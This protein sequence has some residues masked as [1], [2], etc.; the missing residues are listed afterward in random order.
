MASIYLDIY[1]SFLGSIIIY[2]LSRGVNSTG[3]SSMRGV[4]VISRGGGLYVI[5][6]PRAADTE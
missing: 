2:T 5:Y 3:F 6:T 4:Y 1:Q